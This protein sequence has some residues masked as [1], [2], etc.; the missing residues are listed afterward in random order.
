MSQTFL[1]TDQHLDLFLWIDLHAV[2]TRQ[3]SGDRFTQLW[4]S[5]LRRIAVA[6]GLTD[7]LGH[8]FEQL[9]RSRSVRIADTEVDDI[10]A[11][12]PRASL[13]RVELRE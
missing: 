13:C 8:P 1:A 5:L 6:S 4:R 3:P 11:S 7:R 12:G 10:D 2:P 9:S